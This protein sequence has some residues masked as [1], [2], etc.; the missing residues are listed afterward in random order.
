MICWMFSIP[1]AIIELLIIT[2]KMMA[3]DGVCVKM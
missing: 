1:R 2:K 3:A